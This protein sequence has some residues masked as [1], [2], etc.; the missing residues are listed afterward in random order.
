MSI[1]GSDGAEGSG[2]TAYAVVE[3]TSA[4]DSGSASWV[5]SP[6]TSIFVSDGDGVKT[7][8]AFTRDALGHVS[9]PATSSAVVDTTAPAG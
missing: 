7:I 5:A 2:I 8:S 3:G 9:L 4:P 1:D 6:P